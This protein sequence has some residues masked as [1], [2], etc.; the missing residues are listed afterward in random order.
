MR[1]V[2]PAALL[3]GAL[4]A[5]A[6]AV[7]AAGGLDPSFGDGGTFAIGVGPRHATITAAAVQ[8]DGRIVVAGWAERSASAP[9]NRDFL[10]ARLRTDGTLDT[11]FNPMG[12]Q[13]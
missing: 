8:P 7:G 2:L 11:T 12:V 13:P 1:H 4:V 9:V 6:Q 5:P 3:I 10:V